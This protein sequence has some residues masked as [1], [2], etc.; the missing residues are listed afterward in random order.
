MKKTESLKLA[1]KFIK[2]KPMPGSLEKEFKK[3]GLSYLLDGVYRRSA[4]LIEDNQN[5]SEGLK[6]HL[7]QI[8]PCI[9]FYE[10]LL[11][12]EGSREK[13]LVVFESWCFGKIEKMAGMLPKL[14]KIPGLYKKMPALMNKMLDK[15]FGE[16]CGFQYETVNQENGFAAN[17]LVCPYVETC[18]K[19][20]CPELAQFFCKSDDICYANMH[21]KLVWGRTNT[22]GTGGDCCDF[23]LYIK[24]EK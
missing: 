4:E 21:P 6:R 5:V 7:G 16:K 9:A 23:S 12:K 2:K 8:L 14:M 3:Q 19:Y 13:A 22:L 24:P 11:E 17:M 18:K 15:M 1:K 20:G 10:A